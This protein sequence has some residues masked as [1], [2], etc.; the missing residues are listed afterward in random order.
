MSSLSDL[1]PSETQRNLALQLRELQSA[2]S[3]EKLQ[4]QN[5]RAVTTIQALSKELTHLESKYRKLFS[6]YEK[7]KLL[8]RQLESRHTTLRERVRTME[9][10]E[11]RQPR[12]IEAV[13]ELMRPPHIN[14]PSIGNNNET[15]SSAILRSVRLSQYRY[16]TS[17]AQYIIRRP[18]GMDD[19][20]YFDHVSANA[21]Q[22]QANVKDSQTIH[23]VAVVPL[24]QSRLYLSSTTGS[25]VHRRVDGSC[26]ELTV[27][28]LGWVTLSNNLSY[29]LDALVEEAQIFREHYCQSI[30][31]NA[32]PVMWEQRVL[33]RMGRH[34]KVAEQ[35]AYRYGSHSY[36]Q[37]GHIDRLRLLLMG[38]TVLITLL[39]MVLR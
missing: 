34:W 36:Y 10:G 2:Q 20:G 19:S 15:P 22:H 31:I 33:Q 8:F 16:E 23:V 14:Q 39:A 12:E 9:V 28:P 24:D 27:E 29:S 37:K 25:I 6:K 38:M 21:Y 11:K 4:S 30:H 32:K 13:D 5:A 1:R 35:W 26:I 3:M 17:F 7:T 18:Y